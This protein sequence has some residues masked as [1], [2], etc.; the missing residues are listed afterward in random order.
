MHKHSTCVIVAYGLKTLTKSE[1]IS[2]N[3]KVTL[4]GFKIGRSKLH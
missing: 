4:S 2:E 3:P 1:S